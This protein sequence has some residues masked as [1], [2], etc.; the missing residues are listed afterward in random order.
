MKKSDLK[1]SILQC[2]L[3]DEDVPQVPCVYVY[4]YMCVSV[5]VSVH[6]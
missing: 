2:L 1:D 4:V 3:D 5:C 6:V